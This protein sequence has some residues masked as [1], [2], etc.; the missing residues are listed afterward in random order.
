MHIIQYNNYLIKERF[1]INSTNNRDKLWHKFSKRH[2]E[3]GLEPH[4]YQNMMV[5]FWDLVTQ[6]L[7]E[8]NHGV[9]L[10]GLGYFAL[11]VFRNRSYINGNANVHLLPDNTPLY[12]PYFFN[13]VFSG[14][15]LSNV[16]FAA[17]YKIAKATTKLAKAGK[18]Y[19]CHY[20]HIQRINGRNKKYFFNRKRVTSKSLKK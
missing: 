13:A 1:D 16:R 12:E 14:Y 15:E 19:S 10:D 3:F 5:L 9:L 4:Q 11:P 7:I 17:N 6:T 18:K 20:H 2:K 8:S